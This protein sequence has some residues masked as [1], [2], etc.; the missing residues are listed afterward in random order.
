MYQRLEGIEREINVCGGPKHA[1]A[2][3]CSI[4]ACFETAKVTVMEREGIFEIGFYFHFVF[5]T[6]MRVVFFCP[7]N[8]IG[9]T[10][11]ASFITI[12]SIRFCSL[13]CNTIFFS[14]L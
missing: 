8:A 4:H 5:A 7:L 6:S 10:F 9:Y 14:T 2:F 1:Y 3:C 11:S 12:Y 13:P